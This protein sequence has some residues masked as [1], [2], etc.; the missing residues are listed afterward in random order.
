[1]A[2]IVARKKS[3]GTTSYTAQIR[4]KQ[5][6]IVIYSEARTFGKRALAKEWATRREAE[7]KSD[8][9]ALRRVQHRGVI[10]RELI[11]KYIEQRQSVASFGRTKLEALQQLSRMPIANR[12]AL[13]LDRQTV[14]QHIIERR[15]S[16][17]GA[18]ALNDLVW[19]RVVFR[20][21]RTAL[22]IPVDVQMLAD[23]AE[24]C[25][26]ERLVGKSRRRD[27]RPTADELRRIESHFNRQRSSGKTPMPM[28]L[29]MWLAIYSTRR[30]DEL[31]RLRWVDLDR[32][33][34]TWLVRDVKHPDGAEGNHREMR[35]TD[36]MLAVADAIGRCVGC[37]DGRVV[38]FESKSVGTAWY[39]A[40]K[41]LQ[42]E[43]LHFHDL[44]HEGCSRL[45]EDGL[46]IPEIQ[47]VSLHESWGSLQIYVNMR[48]RKH[49]RYEWSSD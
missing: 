44:R 27:R 14:V 12:D 35:V 37:E 9:A 5:H 40:M 43:D 19:L 36:R 29:I 1:M 11:E 45:A 22:G 23:A 49:E 24:V 3:D 18:T 34:G 41:V 42:I 25:R 39:R 7:L 28:A 46:T 6:G 30:L 17:S 47:Q 16:V 4:I 33:H 31:C 26:A 32:E 13:E 20:Y 8:P 48:A 38:P 2:T 15:S 21:A 10:V